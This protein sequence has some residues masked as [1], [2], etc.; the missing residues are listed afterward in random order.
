LFLSPFTNQTT[1]K[2]VV[3]LL[4]LSLS[5]SLSQGATF[6]EMNIKKKEKRGAW[7]PEGRTSKDIRTDDDYEYNFWNHFLWCFSATFSAIF[8]FLSNG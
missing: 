8:F 1:E 2:N 7:K 5:L 4:S 6:S 3:S